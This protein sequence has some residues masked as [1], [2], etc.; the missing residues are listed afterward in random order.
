M[1]TRNTTLQGYNIPKGAII[2]PDLQSVH[3]DPRIFPNPDTFEPE[4]FLDK[5]GAVINAEYC[6]PF[7]VGRYKP[8]KLVLKQ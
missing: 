2:M 1:T 3:K 5:D 7:S 6:I 4:H 8:Q